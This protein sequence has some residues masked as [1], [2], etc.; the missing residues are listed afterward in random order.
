MYPS[1]FHK[2]QKF[3]LPPLSQ[4]YSYS[5][6]TEI[7]DKSHHNVQSPCAFTSLDS[8]RHIPFALLPM[9]AILNSLRGKHPQWSP[10]GETNM[11]HAYFV[12][13]TKQV[14]NA[15]KQGDYPCHKTTENAFSTRQLPRLTPQY[16]CFRS[17]TLPLGPI[18][19]PQTYYS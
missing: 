1:T 17:L 14:P 8:V 10:T 4:C 19:A 11:Q 7:H 13:K 18:G 5:E 3:V 2:D 12:E 15:S 16:R 9:S 6:H